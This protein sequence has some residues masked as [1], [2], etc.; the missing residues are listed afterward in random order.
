MYHSITPRLLFLI[1]ASGAMV[2]AGVLYF[3]IDPMP[4][5]FGTLGPLIPYLA[6]SAFLYSTYS[7]L[8]YFLFNDHWKGRMRAIA[9][10]NLLYCAFTSILLLVYQTSVLYPGWAYFLSEVLVIALLA[11]FELSMVKE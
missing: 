7:F 2:T 5:I 1:D 6:F 3:L 10:A 11:R 4:H 9:Y 8:C